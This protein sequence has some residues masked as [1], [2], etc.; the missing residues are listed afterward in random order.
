MNGRQEGNSRSFSVDDAR[1]QADRMCLPTRERD[2]SGR[3]RGRPYPGRDP[4]RD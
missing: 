3:V 4:R 2:K 1:G